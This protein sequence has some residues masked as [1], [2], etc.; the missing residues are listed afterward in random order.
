M[1]RKPYVEELAVTD[2]NVITASGLGSLEFARE[3]IQQLDLRQR[4]CRHMV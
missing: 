1:K 4:R 2:S 3:V